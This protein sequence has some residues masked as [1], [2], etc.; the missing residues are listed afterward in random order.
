MKLKKPASV[1]RVRNHEGIEGPRPSPR[2]I[3]R[4]LPI[5]VCAGLLVATLF[6][7]AGS[8]VANAAPAGSQIYQLQI[9]GEI[10]PILA[11]YIVNGI[12]AANAQ[13]ASLILITIDTPGGLDTSMREIIGAILHSTVPVVTYV[14][15]SGSRAASAGFFILLSG[16][17]AAMSPGTDTGAASPLLEFAGSPVKI[18]DTLERKIMN[19]AT[20]YL[21]SYAQRRGRNVALAVTAV[22]DAK[23]FSEKEAL[24]GKLI[25]IVAP[26]TEALL[27]QLNGRT[28]TRLDGSTQKLN[29][30]QA[31]VEPHEMSGRE[32]FLDRIVQP[33][34]FFI[35]LI[36]GVLGIYAEF[37]HPGMF[38]PGVIGG[39]ALVLA[40][41][42][43]HM[44]PVNF[45]GV[46]L[47][48]LAMI[49]FVM[50]AK[51]PTHGI[52]GVGGAIAMVLGALMLVHSRIT[53]GG[54]HPGIALAVTIPVAIIV[55]FLMRL[56]LRSFRWKR[57][58][59]ADELLGAVGE[60]IE[61]VKLAGANGMVLIHGELW[62]AAAGEP[63]PKGVRVRV[64][65][66]QGLTLFV[67]PVP[68]ASA[69]R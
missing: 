51:F 53:T 12:E 64:S 21:R 54:V 39:I 47:I 63:I 14:T 55:I 5:M 32:K 27:A 1:P 60:I 38:T 18:D 20:A 24:D 8:R 2:I 23:A 31:V 33:D 65:R 26:S 42:A 62:R 40:L 43:M 11:E 7:F 44:L 56:V 45:T 61:P 19:E 17:V 49:L 3:S 48:L 34:A 67:E 57:T 16:D 36:I 9:N 10:E 50:E 41:F 68:I 37:T 58:T 59:G 25:D 30:A 13:H 46:V 28:I 35:L 15:P 6:V 52:L 66:V 29:L 4:A 22:T 69:S